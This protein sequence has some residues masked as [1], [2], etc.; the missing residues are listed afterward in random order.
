MSHQLE[1]HVESIQSKD[2]STS[3]PL[4]ADHQSDDKN[5]SLKEKKLQSTLETKELDG[6]VSLLQEKSNKETIIS[7][8]ES[9]T[10]PTTLKNTKVD[11]T[12]DVPVE[13]SRTEHIVPTEITPSLRS[14]TENL[15]IDQSNNGKG[16]ETEHEE[17]TLTSTNNYEKATTT[18][19]EENQKDWNWGFNWGSTS[20]EEITEEEQ[21]NAPKENQHGMIGTGSILHEDI[22][23][24]QNLNKETIDG[25]LQNNP[26]NTNS[27][28]ENIKTKSDDDLVQAI[29]NEHYYNDV[30]QKPKIIMN[31]GHDSNKVTP[32]LDNTEYVSNAGLR[33]TT[34]NEED[35]AHGKTTEMNFISTSSL[36]SSTEKQII[37][38]VSYANEDETTQK[39]MTQE[40]S[41][42]T[43]GL[44]DYTDK[45]E[46]ST[47]TDAEENSKGWGWGWSWGSSSIEEVAEVKQD[48]AENENQHDII[49]TG[50]ILPT[51]VITTQNHSEMIQNILDIKLSESEK[52]IIDSYNLVGNLTNH[53]VVENNEENILNEAK[54]VEYAEGTL[55]SN[56]SLNTMT[57]SLNTGEKVKDLLSIPKIPVKTEDTKQN[58]LAENES[59]KGIVV[60]QNSNKEETTIDQITTEK[61][62]MKFDAKTPELSTTI[63]T[64]SKEDKVHILENPALQTTER[65]A[66]IN[67]IVDVTTSTLLEKGEEDV[68]YG[69]ENFWKSMEEHLMNDEKSIIKINK[70]KEIIEENDAQNYA[71]HDLEQADVEIKSKNTVYKNLK[72]TKI[73]DISIESTDRGL[74]TES[75][76]NAKLSEKV[77]YFVQDDDIQTSTRNPIN[78]ITETSSSPDKEIRN[79]SSG[80]TDIDLNNTDTETT[81]TLKIE[82]VNVKHS[83]KDKQI[84]RTLEGI[85]KESTN[86]QFG[87]LKQN[88]NTGLSTQDETVSTAK[89]TKLIHGLNRLGSTTQNYIEMGHDSTNGYRAEPIDELSVPDIENTKHD[90]DTGNI[91]IARD[92][93]KIDQKGEVLHNSVPKQFTDPNVSPT[94]LQLHPKVHQTPGT[95][96]EKTNKSEEQEVPQQQTGDVTLPESLATDDIDH[97]ENNDSHKHQE[98][99]LGETFIDENLQ[100]DVAKI[101]IEHFNE[102][103]HLVK[104]KE[105]KLDFSDSVNNRFFLILILSIININA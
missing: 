5:N 18:E 99:A 50:H 102:D 90:Y 55:V 7:I 77:N 41:V 75:I 83:G 94:I 6:A 72:N 47:I 64:K 92:N 57:G 2:L 27:E 54:N 12:I 59:P 88:I 62:R 71:T 104:P 21:V 32:L 95:H 89:N 43:T 70:N 97:S 60:K 86:R 52:E 34:Q 73:K 24:T 35:K 15:I 3:V 48:K 9:S 16:Y 13:V 69:S 78:L 61:T 67:T 25:M 31:A 68:D 81:A 93:S 38:E 74:E 79:L 63:V 44:Y 85:G 45:Y 26:E 4:K 28:Q 105:F 17:V 84:E 37:S 100:H 96:F 8:K 56:Q 11:S 76:E 39:Q 33:S 46:K 65:Y 87:E 10:T 58:V 49:G 14:S 19:Q 66:T 98:S 40:A 29:T 22:L 23:I 80:E 82:A 36:S 1:T 30:P 101:E 51:D 42:K 103:E 91:D 53:G 20:K